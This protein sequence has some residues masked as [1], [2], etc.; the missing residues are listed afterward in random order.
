MSFSSPTHFYIYDCFYNVRVKERW[1]GLG[2]VFIIGLAFSRIAPYFA[3]IVLFSISFGGG[4]FFL[5]IDF[6]LR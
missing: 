2:R 1:G 4:L 5:G 3:S 6:V